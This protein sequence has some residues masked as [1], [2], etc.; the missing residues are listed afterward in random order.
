MMKTKT[1]RRASLY[2]A[3]GICFAGAVNAQ[4]VT[5]TIYGQA[6]AEPG[7]TIVV[8]NTGTGLSRTIQV[9]SNGRYRATSLPNG[10]YKVTMMK[11]GQVI[12]SREGV[13]VI[14]ASGTEVSFTSSNAANAVDLDRVTVKASSV[15]AIDISQVDTRTVFT[16][17][18]LEKFAI[19]RDIA[20]VA[21]L[22]PQR[23]QERQLWRPQLRRFRII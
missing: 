22:A 9:D 10:T 15:P 12:G 5:G 14:I 20:S 13:S 6:S 2:V 4:S 21:L 18:Q 7:T 3:L 1:I 23:R 19:P 11:D 16:A 17:E 8:E